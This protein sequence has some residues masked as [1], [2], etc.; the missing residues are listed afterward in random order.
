MRARMRARWPATVGHGRSIVGHGSRSRSLRGGVRPHCHSRS[1]Q[2]TAALAGH[3][4]SRQADEEGGRSPPLS[5][6]GAQ[7]N[8]PRPAL[9]GGGFAAFSKPVT[10]VSERGRSPPLSQPV[11]AGRGDVRP[12]LRPLGQDR[13]GLG[14]PRL[15]TTRGTFAPIAS[16]II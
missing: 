12:R 1:R 6:R 16:T 4:R 2:A 3:G 14:R 5:T 11:T 7:R 9:T 10:V 15:A 8:G 13:A